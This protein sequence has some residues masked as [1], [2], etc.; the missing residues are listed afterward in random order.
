MPG[1]IAS[2]AAARIREPA[3]CALARPRRV[4]Y[5]EI[6]DVDDVDALVAELSAALPPG[7]E[8]RRNREILQ[9]SLAIFDRT[10]RVTAVLQTLAGVVAALGLFGGFG[11][12]LERQ[13]QFGVMR[14]LG[15]DRRTPAV[16]TSASAVARRPRGVARPTGG[17][18][19]R[20]D[21]SRRRQRP[22]LRLV[23]GTR[24][25]AG[26]LLEAVFVALLAG[27]VASIAPAI[28][29]HGTAPA[30]LLAQARVA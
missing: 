6:F 5:L 16:A 22:R 18:R 26:L 24:P 2:T 8:V 25:H 11:P 21:P 17:R 9:F 10:F 28:R 23:P 3:G 14:T 1:S 15:L 30:E 29:L 27:A 12:A 19:R 20:G 4:H 13:A 7:A